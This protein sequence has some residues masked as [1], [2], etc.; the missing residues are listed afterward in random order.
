M[1]I[2]I[3]P[4]YV[5]FFEAH[6]RKAYRDILSDE[7]ICKYL[8]ISSLLSSTFLFINNALVWE[9]S[10]EYPKATRMIFE[11]EN[12]GIVKAVSN[13]ANRSE[14]IDNRRK[15]YENQKNTFSIYF[16]DDEKLDHLPWPKN[17]AL[18]NN[19]TTEVMITD[20]REQILYGRNSKLVNDFHITEDVRQTLFLFN[21]NINSFEGF[22]NNSYNNFLQSKNI[23]PSLNFDFGRIVNFLYTKRYLNLFLDSKIL[24]GVPGF[25]DHFTE[26]KYDPNYDYRIFEL[27]FGTFGIFPESVEEVLALKSSDF[28]KEILYEI[29]IVLSG[30]CNYNEIRKFK[31]DKILYSNAIYNRLKQILHNS[32]LRR[33][34]KKSLSVRLHVCLISLIKIRKNLE[35]NVAF[36]EGIR[37][38]DIL[39]KKKILIAVST[40][41]ELKALLGVMKRKRMEFEEI[42]ISDYVYYISKAINKNYDVYIVKTQMGSVNY[43]GSVMSLLE[44]NNS[45]NPDIFIMAGICFGLRE[46]KNNLGDVIVARQI[47]PYEAAKVSDGKYFSRGA[48]LPTSMRLLNYFE[49]S[50]ITWKN[51]TIDFGLFVSGE[52]L[53]NSIEFVKWLRENAPEAIAGDMEATGLANVG[54]YIKKDWILLKSICDWGYK[55]VDDCQEMAAY[56]VME[57]LIHTLKNHF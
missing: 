36:R 47:W 35:K 50:S 32:A 46:H 48:I 8:L 20:F 12:V 56:N 29:R 27:L 49:A 55:K 1:D 44:A 5:H 31:E 43:G 11:L 13:F 14:F 17:I 10:L 16:G 6:Y 57:Y 40:L 38:M 15:I 4:I 34:A 21:E 42:H 24:C 2:Y 25:T 54:Y 28:F 23:M 30:I 18:I 33:D 51:C 41:T 39:E 3:D 37:G 9:S 19:Y 45:I 22:N 53:V 7:K 26:F 52:K